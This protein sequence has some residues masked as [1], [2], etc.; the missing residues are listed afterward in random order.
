MIPYVPNIPTYKLVDL[1]TYRPL[2]APLNLCLKP[3]DFAQPNFI[4]FF[5]VSRP[6]F[7]F[8]SNHDPTACPI[9][10]P[11][12]RPLVRSAVP[13][14]ADS[15]RGRTRCCP[16]WASLYPKG[17]SQAFCSETSPALIAPM[18]LEYQ[19]TL[20]S[21]SVSPSS[22]STSLK[23]FSSP[24][25]GMRSNGNQKPNGTNGV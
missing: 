13:T 2:K 4:I 19:A 7:H 6:F 12:A 17:S 14:D 25:S 1:P 11:I 15:R 5:W 22:S 16:G 23:P 18:R 21:A 3:G 9:A 8:G 24:I 20:S 10:R